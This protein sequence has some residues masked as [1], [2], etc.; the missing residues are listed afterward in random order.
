MTAET[1]TISE[2]ESSC[3]CSTVAVA[4]FS[5]TA[6]LAVVFGIL[7]VIGSFQPPG[8]GLYDLGATFHVGGG[9]GMIGAGF[10]V[11]VIILVARYYYNSKK[12]EIEVQPKSPE[13]S[14]GPP[15][16][17]TKNEDVDEETTSTSHKP[18]NTTENKERKNRVREGS[19]NVLD[20]TKSENETDELVKKINN[21]LIEI[22][23]IEETKGKKNSSDSESFN[24]AG[25]AEERVVSAKNEKINF[26]SYT[27]K[28]K[29][30]ERFDSYF[31]FC[32]F[33]NTGE[34]Y[35]NFISRDSPC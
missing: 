18:L 26:Y 7:S 4:A 30:S 5:V 3:W 22:D 10:V 25:S 31:Q 14:G 20:I 33:W 2:R 13:G 8:T 34:K 12:K 11:L 32:N 23:K 1:R 15:Q 21:V 16:S 29:N 28:K 35:K 17:E 24:Q 19:S 9:Y 6:A 27:K